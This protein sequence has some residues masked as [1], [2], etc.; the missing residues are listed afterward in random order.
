MELNSEFGMPSQSSLRTVGRYFSACPRDFVK[1][2]DGG[3]QGFGAGASEA[4]RLGESAVVVAGT[5]VTAYAF[6]WRGVSASALA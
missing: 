6:Q 5:E 2:I 1:V 3:V 4:T